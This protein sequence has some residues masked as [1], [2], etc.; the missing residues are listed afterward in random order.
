M[1][2]AQSISP[3]AKFLIA[4][5]EKQNVNIRQSPLHNANIICPL[6][7]FFVVVI[8]IAPLA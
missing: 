8:M 2:L 5:S 1:V 4:I 6:L 7:C 3:D